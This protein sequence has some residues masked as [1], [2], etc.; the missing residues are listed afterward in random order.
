MALFFCSKWPL[1]TFKQNKNGLA[2]FQ[3]GSKLYRWLFFRCAIVGELFD[4]VDALTT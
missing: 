2:F 1:N 3:D 4:C